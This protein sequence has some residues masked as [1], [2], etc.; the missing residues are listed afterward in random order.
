MSCNHLSLNAS[1]WVCGET[2]VQ[3]NSLARADIAALRARGADVFMLKNRHDKEGIEQ[4]RRRLW[5][6][7]THVVLMWLQPDEIAVIHPILRRRKNFSVVL[8]DWWIIPHWFIR[9]AE[10]KIF[11][12]YNGLAVRLG[13][14]EFVSE[15]PPLLVRPEPLCR[16]SIAATLLRLPAL[17]VSPLVDLGKWFQRRGE[18][19]QPEKLFYFP[20]PVIPDAVPFKPEKI[21]YDFTLTSS[22]CGV[23][24]MRDAYAPFKHTF[25]NLYCDRQRLMDGIVKLEDKSFKLYDWRWRSEKG[26]V[27]WEEYLLKNRQS[28]Y[29]IATGGLQNANVPKFLEFAC[30]GTPMIGRSLPFECPWIDECLFPVDTMHLTPDQLKP[31]LHQAVERYPVLRE[32]CLKWRDRLLE[33]YDIHKLLDMLQA[34][35][36]GK[37]IPPGYLKTDVK[38]IS[39]ANHRLHA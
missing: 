30:L 7:D 28:R 38:Q 36:D 11:R 19:V 13:H 37:P 18:V 34:Q 14:A 22:T 33:L 29:A 8:D 16:Y 5:S 27:T 20:F 4:L 6:C 35:A 26:L 31:L 2:I 3:W 17:A 9:N 15:T 1:L 21:E 32:N 24:L 23:W 25:A 12:K 39:V 10:Y